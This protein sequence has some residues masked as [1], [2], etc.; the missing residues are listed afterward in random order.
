MSE[1]LFSNVNTVSIYQNGIERATMER[2]NLI[3]YCREV[4]SI[5]D[6]EQKLNLL[7][8]HGE[9]DD[10]LVFCVDVVKRCILAVT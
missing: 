9:S 3:P 10:V 1:L 4:W 8:R 2:F 6:G 7:V 5:F